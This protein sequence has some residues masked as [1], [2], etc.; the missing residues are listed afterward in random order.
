M[1]TELEDQISFARIDDETRALLKAAWPI[2]DKGL[3]D[4]LDRMYAHVLSRPELKAM[5]PSDE[6]VQSARQRQ[7]TH[8]Q[9]L[10]SAAFDDD[11]VASVKRIATTHARIGLDPAFY[12]STY[13]IAL[14][15]IH[16]L[17]IQQDRHHM[18]TRGAR[19]DLAATVQAIDRAIVFDLQLVVTTYLD[20]VGANY[21]SRLE[22]LAD[23]IDNSLNGFTG[24]IKTAARDLTDSSS[25]L[26]DSSDMVTSEVTTLAQRAE[27]SSANMQT[28]ASAAE[29][30][31]ASIGE[32]TRQTR[33]AAEVTTAAVETVRRAGEIVDTLST[34]ALKIGDVVNLIQNI[35]GQTNL[36]ALNATIEAARAGDAGKGFAVVAGEVKTLSG[37]TARATD[38]IRLQVNAVQDV[39]ARIAASMTDITQAVDRIRETTDSIAG[40]VDQQGEATQEISRSVAAAAAS[41]SGFSDGVRN[42]EQFASQNA[43][44]ARG[45][46]DAAGHMTSRSEALSAET[47]VLI[48]RIR[49]ADRRKENRSTV[50]AKAELLVNGATFGAM[51]VNVSDGG[52]ALRMDASRLPAI[53]QNV[54][55][56]VLGAPTQAA[57]RIVNAAGGLVNLSFDEK[58]EGEVL[59]RWL[60]ANR[61][62][63]EQRAA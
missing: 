42:I 44:R 33:E 29:E 13:L 48:A 57:S 3:P 36:L 38:D 1:T 9:H 16:G 51:V 27:E 34:T 55:L 25:A 61:K 24:E 39:V 26:L 41:A 52:A 7:R 54:A 50:L 21:R 46:S 49:V 22:E 15:G 14:E 6:R 60:V 28:V 11:Y 35:A 10:F 30:I 59:H 17:V 18:L 32:I 63:L 37:Q 8:W 19:R 47:G 31:S 23:Q 62:T 12:I 4:I 20:E 58:G 5:F 43:D 2:V 56:R 40:A 45:L 53:R